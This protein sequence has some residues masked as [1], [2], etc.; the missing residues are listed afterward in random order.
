PEAA[1]PP[2]PGQPAPVWEYS[3]AYSLAAEFPSEDIFLVTASPVIK[4]VTNFKQVRE[5]SFFLQ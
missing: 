1:T 2:P 4:A 3:Q 5:T